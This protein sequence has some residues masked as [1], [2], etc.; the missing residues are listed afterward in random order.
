MP[1]PA[2]TTKS[3]EGARSKPWAHQWWGWNQ[4]LG[5][6]TLSHGGLATASRSVP[7]YPCPPMTRGHVSPAGMQQW[8]QHLAPGSFRGPGPPLGRGVVHQGPALLGDDPGA[9]PLSIP[10]I[11]PFAV[12]ESFSWEV[13]GGPG[14]SSSGPTDCGLAGPPSPV[15]TSWGTA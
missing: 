4:N 5:P 7:H 2:F 10:A 15:A 6:W 9:C 13:W 1:S 11:A 3:S 14:P 12:T 8:P